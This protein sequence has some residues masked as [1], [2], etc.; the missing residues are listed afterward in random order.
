MRICGRLRR[1]GKPEMSYDSAMSIPSSFDLV[2]SVATIYS[3]ITE[4]SG[5]CTYS[6]Q[7]IIMAYGNR[8]KIVEMGLQLRRYCRRVPQVS[9]FGALLMWKNVPP[10]ELCT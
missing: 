3:R 1:K 7:Y 2:S 4:L 10:K 5:R 9:A 6:S 8:L